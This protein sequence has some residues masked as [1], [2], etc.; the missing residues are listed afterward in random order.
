LPEAAL[1]VPRQTTYTGPVYQ[2]HIQY[3]IQVQNMSGSIS[4]HIHVQHMGG[5]SIGGA[6]AAAATEERLDSHALLVAAGLTV[7]RLEER[8]EALSQAVTR[9]FEQSA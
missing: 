1:A 6:P 2:Y 9:G 4:D 5:G 7:T 3:H 8:I